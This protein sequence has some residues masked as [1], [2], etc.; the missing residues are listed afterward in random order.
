[1]FTQD[2]IGTPPHKHTGFICRKMPDDI[3]LDFKKSIIA[4]AIGARH[5]TITNKRKT[6]PKQPADNTLRGFLVGFLEKLPTESAFLR[7]QINQLFIIEID[8]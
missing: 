6:H 5:G 7:S 1:M 8:A 3:T 2:V 4:Q